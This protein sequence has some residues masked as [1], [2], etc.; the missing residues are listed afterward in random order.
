M[1]ATLC[2]AWF[3][4]SCSSIVS[5]LLLRL[6]I[7]S[8]EPAMSKSVYVASFTHVSRS[9]ITVLGQPRYF[10]PCCS[11]IFRS[12]FILKRYFCQLNADLPVNRVAPA[13]IRTAST[14]VFETTIPGPEFANTI[15]HTGSLAS[16]CPCHHRRMNQGVLEI[17]TDGRRSNSPVPRIPTGRLL[18][19]ITYVAVPRT[20]TKACCSK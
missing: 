17:I 3:A 1:L 7:R 2:K 4:R 8:V 6:S 9:L 16:T 19:S 20:S 10:G 12:I 11:K 18:T 13:Y 15:R 5:E 14:H